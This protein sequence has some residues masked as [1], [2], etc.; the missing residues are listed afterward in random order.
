MCRVFPRRFVLPLN[1]GTETPCGTNLNEQTDNTATAIKISNNKVHSCWRTFTHL[2]HTPVHIFVSLLNQPY[3]LFA[4]SLSLLIII[5][6]I[7]IIIISQWCNF[8]PSIQVFCTHEDLHGED[9]HVY[10]GLEF[11]Q[12][13]YAK[14]NTRPYRYF[15][16]C[17]F[18]HLVGDTLIK[19]DIHSKQMKVP[20]DIFM[21]HKSQG[22]DVHNYLYN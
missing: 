12:I 4:F 14:Y 3:F 6:I 19:M 16:G 11:P 5:I 20:L 22:F 8:I 18:R 13:N 15:Y 9:L 10:G 21:L 17:G 7:I 1:V 2:I